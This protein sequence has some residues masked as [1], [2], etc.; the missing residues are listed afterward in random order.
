LLQLLRLTAVRLT[1]TA[2]VRND[3]SIRQPLAKLAPIDPHESRLSLA[4]AG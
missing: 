1:A 3:H 4:Q 2:E